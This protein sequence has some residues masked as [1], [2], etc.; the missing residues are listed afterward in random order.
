[1]S[2]LIKRDL[3]LSFYSSANFFTVSFFTLILILIPFAFGTQTDQLKILF[4]GL[5]WIALALSIIIT[6]DRIFNTDYEDGNL[7][8]IL[9]KN[10]TIE[11]LIISKY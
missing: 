9:Q 6:V 3:L 5:V 4:K 8:I 1:M 11:Y 2:N 7:D 10:K